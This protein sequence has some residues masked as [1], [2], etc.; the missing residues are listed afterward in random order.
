VEGKLMRE[1]KIGD[2]ETVAVPMYH[3]E[4]IRVENREAGACEYGVPGQGWLLV[5]LRLAHAIGDEYRRRH[6]EPV[7]CDNCKRLAEARQKIIDGQLARIEDLEEQ[8]EVKESFLASSSERVVDLVKKLDETDRRAAEATASQEPGKKACKSG[9]IHHISAAALCDAVLFANE[10]YERLQKTKAEAED[11]WGKTI[12]HLEAE[13]EHLRA[14]KR[15]APEIQISAEVPQPSF[16]DMRRIWTD[17]FKSVV[18]KRLAPE[19]RPIETAP[20]DGTQILVYLG[21]HYGINIVVVFWQPDG[22]RWMMTAAQ[23]LEVSATHWQPLP[24]PPK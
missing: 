21:K 3:H 8:L 14:A 6:G 19:W 18:G 12:R 16:E 10:R 17:V 1:L 9:H 24:E 23:P 4:E 2:P 15:S 5:P 22:E 13:V 11:G 7:A 20:K